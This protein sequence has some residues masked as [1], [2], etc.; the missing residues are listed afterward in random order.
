MKAVSWKRVSVLVAALHVASC[1]SRKVLVPPRVDLHA[2]GTI[3][4]IQFS[5]QRFDGSNPDSR[6]E[7]SP[8]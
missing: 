3:G 4:L 8:M 6:M 7:R 2:F 1:A 5:P